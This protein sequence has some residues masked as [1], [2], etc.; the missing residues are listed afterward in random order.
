MFY[1][2][3]VSLFCLMKQ[4]S[5]VALLIG[6]KVLSRSVIHSDHWTTISSLAME[7][8]RQTANRRI[9]MLRSERPDEIFPNFLKYSS[10][11]V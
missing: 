7:I 11:M 3:Y 9:C 8:S 4:E 10:R 1:I 2:I 5:P 6:L